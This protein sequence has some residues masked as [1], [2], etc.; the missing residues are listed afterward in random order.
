[1]ATY[2]HEILTWLEPDKIRSEQ[3]ASVVF[4]GAMSEAYIVS[5]RSACD[6]LAIALGYVATAKLGQAPTESLRGLLE[7]A[8]RIQT[9]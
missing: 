8:R 7:W 6:S 2:A 5:A 4:V 1:M 9:I 3:G